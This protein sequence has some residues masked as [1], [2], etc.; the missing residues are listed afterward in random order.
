MCFIDSNEDVN[1]A[2]PLVGPLLKEWDRAAASHR[3]ETRII[4]DPLKQCVL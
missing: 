2:V 4:K 3:Q 1:G